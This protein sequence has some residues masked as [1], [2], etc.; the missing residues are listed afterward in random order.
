MQFEK[1]E[2]KKLSLIK[3]VIEESKKLRAERGEDFYSE[4]K[5]VVA[6]FKNSKIHNGSDKNSES[7]FR[8][9]RKSHVKL[10]HLIVSYDKKFSEENDQVLSSK[11]TRSFFD[12]HSYLS[13]RSSE[14]FG[15]NPFF[16]NCFNKYSFLI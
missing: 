5:N 4:K 14:V 12:R 16:S 13:I 3:S 10:A 6:E 1:S 8:T 2:N 7:D 15:L 11:K 9:L